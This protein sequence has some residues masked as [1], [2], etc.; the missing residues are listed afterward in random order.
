MGD[1]RFGVP[2]RLCAA[3]KSGM[4]LNR[5]I[6]TGTFIGGS[7]VELRDI[8]DRVWTIE[9]SQHLYEAARATNARDGLTFL[10]G[11]SED[12]LPELLAELDEPALF[13]LDGHWSE[14]ETAGEDRECPVLAEL[15]AID[16]WPHASQSAVLIDD[17]RFFLGP[18]IPPYKP[19]A[20]P[21]LREVLDALPQ[22]RDQYVGVLEDVII[23]GPSSMRPI[24]ERYWRDMFPVAS[25]E[26]LDAAPPE[27]PPAPDPVPI[28][29]A[30]RAALWAR[31][32]WR[33]LPP[34]DSLRR[35]VRHVR[36]AIEA[37]RRRAG[38][39]RT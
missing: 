28:S 2:L 11:S 1:V 9:L 26:A 21:T 25:A 15:A 12:V 19:E 17:A 35:S 7:A 6:E 36:A 22:S 31:A 24:I 3:L 4:A 16:A 37:I 34:S 39:P 10:L 33:D 30:R 29:G 14:G 5:A 32:A 23:A 27:S 20:W 18:P 8:F 13:W 38:H